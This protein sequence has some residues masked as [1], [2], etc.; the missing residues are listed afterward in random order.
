MAPGGSTKGIAVLALALSLAA[1]AAAPSSH[2][3]APCWRAVVKEWAAGHVRQTHSLACYRQAIA[4]APADL[5]LYSSF[6]D[7]LQRIIQS[8]ALRQRDHAE[9]S[10]SGLAAAP[11][12]SAS[13]QPSQEPAASRLGLWIAGAV[14]LSCFALL[15]LKVAHRRPE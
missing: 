14:A 9:R 8:R 12:P 1:L 5:R 13:V 6:E 4:Q 10:L 3:A 2:A 15:V 7:D 11:N